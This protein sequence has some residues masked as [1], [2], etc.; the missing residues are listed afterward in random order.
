ML[1]SA[2]SSCDACA[3]RLYS[4]YLPFAG[5]KMGRVGEWKFFYRLFAG[6]GRMDLSI[7]VEQC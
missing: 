1:L 6:I 2:I 7:S 4:F 5:T 3:D